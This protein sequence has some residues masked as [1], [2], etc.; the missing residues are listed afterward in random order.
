MTFDSHILEYMVK[1]EYNADGGHDFSLEEALW[2]FKFYLW[3]YQK[4]MR[5]EHP[6]IKG[7]QIRNIIE[8]MPS[9]RDGEDI[10]IEAHDYKVLIEKHFATKYQKGCDYNINHF[11]SGDIRLMRYY[12]SGLYGG[13]YCEEDAE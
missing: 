10:A 6:N 9:I 8:A 1:K 3:M 5:R 12:D 4:Q 13:S 11:F 2:V 7:P